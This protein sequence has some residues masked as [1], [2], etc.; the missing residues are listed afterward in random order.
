MTE[1]CLE[2]V[3][4]RLADQADADAFRSAAP[5]V[6]DW[7]AR[8]PG[9]QHR[10]LVEEANGWWTDLIWWRSEAE[11]LSAADKVM[12]ELGS[13]SFMMMIDPMSVESGHHK[14]AH[15]SGG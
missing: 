7:A 2:M 1:H 4:F 15:M 14:V 9:F 13:T 11:A 8:Q 6:T 12:R 3:R 10:T 5:I